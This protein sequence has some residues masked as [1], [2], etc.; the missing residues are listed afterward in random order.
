MGVSEFIDALEDFFKLFQ[1]DLSTWN[2]HGGAG[3]A[4]NANT[5]V[6]ETTQNIRG[7]KSV[8]A[9]QQHVDE[10]KHF[11]SI[12]LKTGIYSKSGKK[13]KPKAPKR[14]MTDPIALIEEN[15]KHKKAFLDLCQGFVKLVTAE[16]SAPDA[17]HDILPSH[18]FKLGTYLKAPVKGMSRVIQ[19]FF[20]KYNCLATKIVDILRCSFVF[21]NVRD[22]YCG[23]YMTIEHFHK[24]HPGAKIGDC[25]WL[26][27]RFYAPTASGYRDVVLQ[28]KVPGS[29]LW[30]EVQFHVKDLLDYKN[31]CMHKLYECL[32]HFPN[33][34]AIEKSIVKNMFSEEADKQYAIP[35]GERGCATDADGKKS[36]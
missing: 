35:H 25:L 18:K 23:L 22:L 31:Q 28:V 36:I 9:Q 6:A 2:T 34:G 12:I 5:L 24:Q 3:K 30:A 26:K 33:A 17:F 19:K 10:V 4:L 14:F 32:R 11:H 29:D 1:K 16:V 27:D 21:D 8:L 7:L 20:Y 13:I 15:K